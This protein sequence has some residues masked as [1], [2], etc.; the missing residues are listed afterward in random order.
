VR[1]QAGRVLDGDDALVGG[2]VSQRGAVHQVADRPH[3]L[4]ARALRAVDG[5]EPRLVELDAGILEAEPLDVGP[6]AGGDDEPVGTVVLAAEGERAVVVVALDVLDEG[7][8]VELDALLLEPALGELGDVGVLG[9]QHAVERL[10][11]LDLRAQARVGRGDLGA[12]RA[13]A[14]DHE[15]RRQLAQRPRLLRADDAPA[16]LRPRDRLLHRAGGEHDALRDVDLVAVLARA[17]AHA[18][19]AGDRAVALEVVD[20]VLLEEPADPAGQ[21]LDH[22][23]AALADG[24]EVDLG[25]GDL[26][27]ELVGVAHLVEDVGH[28]Q[29]RLGRDAGDVEAAPADDVLLDDG[30][31]H[32]ELGGADGGDVATRARADDDAVVLGVSHEGAESNERVA[33]PGSCPSRG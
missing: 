9:R 28:A 26:D 4:H 17:D 16:E 33:A 13:G 5:D 15:L 2:L 1:L 11:E 10:E 20:L 6:A 25:L 12:R 7:A 14:D 8:G 32:A 23:L 31:L 19:G 30:G 3:A 21:R 29:H 18:A 22:L 27:A 24:R